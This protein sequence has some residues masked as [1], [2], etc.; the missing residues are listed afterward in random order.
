MERGKGGLGSVFAVRM[1]WIIP[2]GLGKGLVL[3]ELP[4]LVGG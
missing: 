2:G 4:T 1:R 3:T